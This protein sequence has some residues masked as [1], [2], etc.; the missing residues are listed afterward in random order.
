MK[1]VLINFFKSSIVNVVKALVELVDS[2]RRRGWR[3]LFVHHGDLGDFNGTIE[4]V[5]NGDV[6]CIVRDEFVKTLRGCGAIATYN[7]VR[8]LLGVEFDS[9]VFYLDNARFWPGNL[10]AESVEF[11][12]RGGVYAIH[13]PPSLNTRF[14][15]YFLR[16]ASTS[17]NAL[18]VIDGKVEHFHVSNENPSPPSRPVVRRTGDK[19]LDKILPLTTTIDQ[20]EA[21]LKYPEFLKSGDR[22]FFIHGDRGRGKSS[23]LGMAIAYTMAVRPNRYLV[24]S[25]SLESVQSAFKMAVKCLERLGILGDVIERKGLIQEVKASNG[26][27]IRYE[28]PW[29][30]FNV[31]SRPLFIDEAAAV[32]VARIRRWYLRIGKLVA[33]ST[34]H[35]YEGSGRALLRELSRYFHRTTYVELRT[36]IR[37]YPGDPLEE[38]LYRLFH[39]NAEPI[40]AEDVRADELEYKAITP[41]ELVENYGLLREAYGLLVTAHYRNEPDDLVSIIDGDIFELRV[42]RARGKGVVAIA[43]LREERLNDI[44]EALRA[45]RGVRGIAVLDKISR[46]GLIN[47]V[48]GKRLWRIVRIAV[49]PGLQG[50]GFGSLL[51]GR[52]EE[53]AKRRNFDFLGSIFSNLDV[54]GFWVKN[55]FLPIYLS[56]RYNRVTGEK[57]MAVIKPLNDEARD[58]AY[59]AFRHFV[60]YLLKT[61]HV[62]YT[63][64]SVERIVNALKPLANNVMISHDEVMTRLKM[65]CNDVLQPEMALDIMLDNAYDI[66][67]TLNDEERMLFIARAIQGKSI[68]ELSAIFKTHPNEIQSKI[69]NVFKKALNIICNSPRQ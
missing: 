49:A 66:I 58:V 35:G 38:F 30:I 42:L 11:V 4:Y 6:L 50:R 24:T 17:K 1:V 61:A 53:E 26:S 2:S 13:I 14:T 56:P 52:I 44:D 15:R 20:Y 21:L 33:S 8:K 64:V 65:A 16:V 27:S 68:S 29:R 46:W 31:N 69:E 54:I 40:E 63:D 39:L 7:R 28:M 55:G 57:N 18:V 10:I 3:A 19:I 51:L 41:D 23:L 62:L 5:V 9:V 48:I 67:K 37:Y 12:K 22:L 47:Y 25:Y 32:G 43:Q 36:P 45:L 59:R 60:N 34:T